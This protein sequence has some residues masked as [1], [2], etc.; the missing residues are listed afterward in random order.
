MPFS[1]ALS[2]A[3]NA[4]RALDE[5]CT[6]SR[7][8]LAEKPDLA[9]AFF[10]AH[11]AGAAERIAAAVAERLGPRC[12]LGCVAEAVI[13]GDKEVEEGP[14]LSLWLGRWPGGVALEPFHAVLERTSEGPSLLGL[15]D[16]LVGRLRRLGGAPAG[17][18]V[19]VPGR[20]VPATDERE[21]SR[22]AGAGRHGQRHA[23]P[24][25]VP[26]VVQRRG[27]RR[28]APSAC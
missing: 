20:P 1:A 3:A 8:S 9:F 19:H 16:G 11:H 28:R 21:Q 22:P 7:S 18:S 26:A 12:L 6:N 14:A 2:T 25:R 4:D 5:V 24:R 23:R 17:R 27:P 10:S 13:G 15:P